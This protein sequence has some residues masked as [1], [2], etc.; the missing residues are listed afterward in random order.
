MM[1]A[2]ILAVLK[3]PQRLLQRLLQAVQQT[4]A[5][6]HQ[7]RLVPLWHVNLLL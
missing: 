1:S 4:P 3:K 5:A 7:L 2:A 6:L